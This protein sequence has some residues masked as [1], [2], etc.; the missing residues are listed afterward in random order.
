MPM[1]D[2]LHAPATLAEGKPA[3]AVLTLAHDGRTVNGSF[4]TASVGLQSH[5][6]TSLHGGQVGMWGNFHVEYLAHD[7]EY[8]VWVTDATR[9]ARKASGSV[10]A[11]DDVVPLTAPA[12]DPSAPLFAKSAG[13]G[14]LPVAVEVTVDGQTFSLPFQAEHATHEHAH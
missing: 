1:G 4:E 13:A 10:K 8:R 3:S 12:D 14:S 2:H 7:G 9:N 6:H 11:G 5:D